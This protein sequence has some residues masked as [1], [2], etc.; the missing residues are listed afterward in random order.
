[1][2]YP[3]RIS[4]GVGLPS[5][6]VKRKEVADQ[7]DVPFIRAGEGETERERGRELRW[8]SLQLI[9]NL[10]IAKGNFISPKSK[11]EDPLQD[12]ITGYVSV[13]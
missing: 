2:I 11:L 12:I 1:M 5:R 4:K 10:T 9:R 7:N 6:K 3:I 13:I 8:T